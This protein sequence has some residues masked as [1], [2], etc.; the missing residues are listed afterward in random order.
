MKNQLNNP[1]AK[2]DDKRMYI[3]ALGNAGSCKVQDDLQNILKNKEQPLYIR[4]ESVWALR[5]IVRQKRSKAKVRSF[6]TI[7]C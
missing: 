4:V 5:R 1:N 2:S 7:N 3:Q 6:I